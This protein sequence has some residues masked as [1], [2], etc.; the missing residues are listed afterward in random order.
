MWVLGDQLNPQSGVLADTNPAE[1]RVLFVVSRAMLGQR[2]WH[3]QRLHVV[4]AGMQRMANQLVLDGYQADFRLADSMRAGVRGHLAEFG[5]HSVAVMEPADLR[6]RKTI[7]RWPECNVRPNEQFLC[8]SAAF[9]DWAGGRKSLR[10]E[11]FY[12]WQRSRLNILMDGAEPAGGQ[13]NYDADNREP[14]PKDG[15]AWPAPAPYPLDEVDVEISSLIER[16]APRA[17]GAPWSG[18]WPTTPSQAADRLDRVVREVL[19]RFGPHEDAMLSG[20]WHLAHTALSSS[21]NLGLLAPKQVVGAAEAAY[22]NRSVPLASAEGFIRQVIG[23]RE[24]VYGIAH[25]WGADYVRSNALDAHEP[26]PQAF[27]QPDTTEMA[28]LR[29]VLQGVDERAYAHHIQRL[30]VLGNLG[31]VVGTEPTA[32]NNWMRERFI[33]AADWVMAPNVIGMTLHADG[34]RMATKPYASGGAYISRMS[35][36]CKGCRYDPKQRVGPN[37]CPF[38]SL[39]WDFIAQH[40]TRFK[41][42]HRMTKQVAAAQR[43]TDLDGVRERA[44]E[45][46]EGLRRGEI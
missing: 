25:L 13:W 5:G 32:L 11:D 10:M 15:R 38:S 31:L 21:M 8:S 14:P 26:L 16:C 36:Y 23:W 20:N 1:T 46:R 4:L 37:A 17:C 18:L 12:R 35:D 33:D 19:P 40:E 3:R 7:E 9:A 44:R 34:G 27:E 29:S 45:V 2:A 28:C 42:N 22:R 24:Y 43:L 39:Y 6:L 41:Q 30:M